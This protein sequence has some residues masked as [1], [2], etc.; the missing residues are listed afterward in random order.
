MGFESSFSSEE[1]LFFSNG[2]QNSFLCS[3]CVLG[4]QAGE[5]GFPFILIQPNPKPYTAPVLLLLQ[6]L[7]VMCCNMIKTYRNTS[8][9]DTLPMLN[10]YLFLTLS[11]LLE[12]VSLGF[13]STLLGEVWLK[14]S[15]QKEWKQCHRC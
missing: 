8:F 7:Q 10:Q 3:L 1:G 2:I 5:S 15:E 4:Q 14:T 9:Y 11:E 6:H 13:T 12:D